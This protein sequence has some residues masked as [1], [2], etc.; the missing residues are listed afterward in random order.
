MCVFSTSHTILTPVKGENSGAGCGRTSH[1]ILN[2][3]LS[4]WVNDLSHNNDIFGVCVSQNC[5]LPPVIPSIEVSPG[6]GSDRLE[7][8]SKASND[9]FTV[10]GRLCSCSIH[11]EHTAYIK[12]KTS[13]DCTRKFAP[14]RVEFDLIWAR[15]RESLTGSQRLTA[16]S[17]LRLPDYER[18][19]RSVPTSEIPA[20]PPPKYFKKA[21]RGLGTTFHLWNAGKHEK[22]RSASGSVCRREPYLAYHQLSNISNLCVHLQVSDRNI[23]ENKP[24]MVIIESHTSAFEHLSCP[25]EEWEVRTAVQCP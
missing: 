13:A 15:S 20:E 18:T 2:P 25:L 24:A 10:L 4:E 7:I 12:I 6:E 23:G 21:Y 9:L 14:P 22:I 17:T 1:Q 19:P 11:R 3:L 8:F 5:Q 16:K